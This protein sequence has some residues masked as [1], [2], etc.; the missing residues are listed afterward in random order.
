MV[1]EIGPGRGIITQALLD[2]AGEVLAIEKDPDL[3]G[4]LINKFKNVENLKIHNADFL[5]FTLPSKP[6]KVFA[7]IPFDITAKIVGRLLAAAQM[8]E[9]IYL[10]MQK[11]AAEK[12][13]GVPHETMSS[14]L[15]K[16]WY[17]IETLGNI[18]R[19]NF[20]LKPQVTIVFVKFIKRPLAFIRDENKKSFREFVSYGFT[21]WK[22]TV[23]E[24]YKKKFSFVQF[25]KL[26]KM[27]KL[28]GLAPSEVDFDTWLKLFKTY[29]RL[30]KNKVEV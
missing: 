8:P 21:Q 9:A 11:E 30:N 4:Y 13:M 19:S 5:N 7:N 18:D 17:E 6:Y 16:P 23:L 24:A 25:D 29:E 22:P 28:D 27:L 12:Y 2:R 26:K 20:T 1:L 10:V 3:A 15:A 14:I